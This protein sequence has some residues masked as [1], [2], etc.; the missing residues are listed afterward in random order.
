MAYSEAAGLV[1]TA[2]REVSL[3]DPEH[4]VCLARYSGDAEMTA[5]A[6]GPKGDRIV[7]G[8]AVGR[9]HMLEPRFRT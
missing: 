6:I 2:S 9:V 7:V 5:C 3:W 1:V 8:D 4:W